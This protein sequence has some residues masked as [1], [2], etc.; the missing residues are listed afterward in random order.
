MQIKRIEEPNISKEEE[1]ADAIDV[2]RNKGVFSK[3]VIEVSEEILRHHGYSLAEIIFLKATKI[4]PRRPPSK[5][6]N[7]R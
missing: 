2:L 1:I 3:A 7:S 5:N 4:D 6:K